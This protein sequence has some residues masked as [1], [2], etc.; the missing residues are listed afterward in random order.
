[1]RRAIGKLVTV[2]AVIAATASLTACDKPLP[3]ITVLSGSTTVVVSPQS[4]CN[5]AAHCHFPT[6]TTKVVGAVAGSQLL[7]DVPRQIADHPWLAQSGTISNDTLK[8]FVGENYTTGT[9]SGSH[10]A[11]V[12]V[13]YGVG[14]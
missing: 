10:T 9:V 4:Y 11:R 14:K 7:I 2:A 6:K 13:P 8:T 5:D 3:E 1:M 12:D